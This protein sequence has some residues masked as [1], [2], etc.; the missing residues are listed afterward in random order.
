MLGG[1]GGKSEINVWEAHNQE[2]TAQAVKSPGANL[3]YPPQTFSLNF[4]HLVATV[5]MF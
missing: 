1:V 3:N 4:E 2:N 5:R